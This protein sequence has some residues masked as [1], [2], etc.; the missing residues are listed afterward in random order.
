VEPTT[1]NTPPK[2]SVQ[3]KGIVEKQEMDFAPE[4]PK[5]TLLRDIREESI[6][7][8]A[9]SYN[10]ERGSLK[11]Q[12][13]LMNQEPQSAHIEETLPDIRPNMDV[14]EVS[15]LLAAQIKKSKEEGLKMERQIHRYKKLINAQRE[16]LTETQIKLNEKDDRQAEITDTDYKKIII[17]NQA[18]KR[19]LGYL[20]NRTES[21]VKEMQDLYPIEFLTE[22]QTSEMK[23]DEELKI[24]IQTVNNALIMSTVRRYR[25]LYYSLKAFVEYLFDAGCKGPH[26]QHMRLKYQQ[27]KHEL[28][29]HRKEKAEE[30]P[31]V[32]AQSSPT[33]NGTFW[34]N[35][36]KSVPIARAL[37]KS[38]PAPKPSDPAPAPPKYE[39]NGNS[40]AK[41]TI[42][43]NN[44]E[45]DSFKE[46]SSELL[47]KN[48]ELNTMRAS[49]LFNKFVEKM[50]L[51]QL[52]AEL[53]SLKFTAG[54]IKPLN[55]E[56]FQG[57]IEEQKKVVR[58]WEAKV[59][60]LSAHKKNTAQDALKTLS[61][62]V[63]SSGQENRSESPKKKLQF[64]NVKEEVEETSSPTGVRQQRKN[65]VKLPYLLKTDTT[66][67]TT[68][69][70][71]SHSAV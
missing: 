71:R 50:K 35:G 12:L 67:A 11:Q 31:M 64:E 36:Q 1:E 14:S 46:K 44:P 41:L 68:A 42:N 54:G 5:M 4:P 17:D 58:K 6:N 47:K 39:S 61:N 70:P 23:E 63:S 40:P 15:Q 13:E 29:H 62:F 34:K 18:I 69:Q 10:F 56:V 38:S 48:R 60:H 30:T 25:V 32:S 8:M 24:E 43:T 27:M 2:Q 55:T 66:K 26:E 21:Y 59:K 53:H 45:V 49:A 33:T 20:H 22:E 28:E 37:E 9:L 19:A 52:Q 16:K 51:Q 7:P 3:E 65:S 57:L